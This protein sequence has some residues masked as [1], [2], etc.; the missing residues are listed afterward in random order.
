MGNTNKNT[1]NRIDKDIFIIEEKKD[2]YLLPQL[3]TFDYLGITF[4][5]INFP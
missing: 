3:I 4:V 1:N 5:V 2:F